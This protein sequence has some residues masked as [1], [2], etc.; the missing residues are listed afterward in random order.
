[1]QNLLKGNPYL[2]KPINFEVEEASNE[3][4]VLDPNDNQSDFLNIE[5]TKIIIPGIRK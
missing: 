3:N 5:D 1:M 2:I 4:Y